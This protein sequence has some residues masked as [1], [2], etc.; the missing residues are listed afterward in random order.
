MIDVNTRE[1]IHFEKKPDVFLPEASDSGRI[2]AGIV[3]PSY[4]GSTLLT[5]LL[6][7][8]SDIFEGGELHWLL[9]NDREHV[10][11]IIHKSESLLQSELIWKELFER[12]V[13]PA[14]LYDTVFTS[15]QQSIVIDSSKRPNYF[16]QMAQQNPSMSFLFIYLLKHP[17]RLLAS[18]VMH[19]AQKPECRHM[20]REQVIEY[21]LD[22]LHRQIVYQHLISAKIGCGNRILVLKYEDIVTRT[23]ETLEYVLRELGLSFQEQMLEYD[24]Q[25][26]HMLG[27]NAG[28][29][30]QISRSQSGGEV[31]FSSQIQDDFYKD[32]QGI[33][34]DNNYQAC[35]SPAEINRLN[36]SEKM[37]TLL[38]IMGY[39]AIR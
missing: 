33:K 31:R 20:S 14:I 22:D 36:M 6:G 27:G 21:L 10:E 38:H 39:E 24:R 26:H 7:S 13:T 25:E 37:L 9:S 2:V 34:M 32:L 12:E 1:G 28:P 8:H 35:F 15:V 18:H 29:R 17:M 19:R 5:A 11:K 3:C 30:S 16:E 23:R 4:S